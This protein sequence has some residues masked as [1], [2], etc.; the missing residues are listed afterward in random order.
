MSIDRSVDLHHLAS[1]IP[2]AEFLVAFGVPSALAGIIG[3]IVTGILAAVDPTDYALRVSD[4]LAARRAAED[5][6]DEK[7]HDANY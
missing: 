1:V 6:I 3:A 2:T 4:A 7:L 5:T